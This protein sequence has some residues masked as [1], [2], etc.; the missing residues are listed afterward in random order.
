MRA[1]VRIEKQAARERGRPHVVKDDRLIAVGEDGAE[2]DI[3]SC[4]TAGRRHNGWR[5]KCDYRWFRSFG[6]SRRE[7]IKRALP[8]LWQ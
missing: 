5:F 4:V 2:V 3:S 7:A 8:R 6:D 1:H